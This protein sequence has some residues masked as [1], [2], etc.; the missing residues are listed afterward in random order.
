MKLTNNLSEHNNILLIIA[1]IWTTM[2][3]YL[4]LISFQTLPEAPKN[5]D[6]FGH[7]IF[8]FGITF[9]WFLYFNFKKNTIS[10]KNALQKAFLFSFFY[11]IIIEICQWFFTISRNAEIL[12]VLANAIGASLAVM[13]VAV[14]S[15]FN[16]K[17]PI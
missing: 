15:V 13:I 11:G 17:K 1:L 4:C 7:I 5:F 12:D 2:V 10:V 6:K 8:H 16:K 14:F 3:A 9:L